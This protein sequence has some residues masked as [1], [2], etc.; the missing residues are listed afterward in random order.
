[1]LPII[2]TLVEAGLKII[3]KVI[4]DPAAKA[5]AK[6][7]LIELQQKGELAE[8]AAET[9]LAMGQL[10]INKAEA[11]NANIFVSGWRPAVGWV[12]VAG[13][14][15][16]YVIGPLVEWLSALFWERITWPIMN[17]GELMTLLV[18]M[19][20]LGALRTTEKVKGVS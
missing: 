2:G 17:N 5:E 15:S 20:G 12:C 1:M 6:L 8:L 13:L 4:P 3:D 14:G 10:E 16:Q 9:Q 7:R 11:A 19:L 18:G